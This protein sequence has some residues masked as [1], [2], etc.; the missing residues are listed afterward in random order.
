MKVLIANNAKALTAALAEHDN[1]A[2]VEAEYGDE[3]VEGALATLA[4]HGKYSH[5]P[6]PCIAPMIPFRDHAV[7]GVLRLKGAKGAITEE[8]LEKLK[9]SWSEMVDGA[10][11]FRS[12]VVAGGEFKVCEF[13]IDA[14]GISHVDL[15][16]L[17]GIL[18]LLG[19][20]RD[21]LVDGDGLFWRVAAKVDLRGAHHLESILD[22]IP[23]LP[24]SV[25]EI[26][27]RI[28]SQLHAWWGWNE[29]NRIYPPQD[30]SVADVTVQIWRAC[31]A[32]ERI[33][34]GEPSHLHYGEIWL[35]GQ[36]A[37]NVESFMETMRCGPNGSI[38]V[39]RRS[40]R[41]CGHL[42]L[43]PRGV[44]AQAMA[45]YNLDT[46]AIT[47]SLADPIEGVNCEEIVKDL[48]G[49][50]AGGRDV[51]AGSPRGKVMEIRE[52]RRASAAIAKAIGNHRPR[53]PGGG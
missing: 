53:R 16:T 4:H 9:K 42:Y 17:G 37:L 14:I 21:D 48:W 12:P 24:P 34:E 50:E 46:S 1:T 47:V 35:A 6:A 49:P 43:T 2:T 18:G 40:N 26:A 10:E 20:R 3:V 15:D 25:D 38:V 31:L 22:G 36:E 33:L 44:L 13:P 52:L 8:Q 51:V 23:L 19:R 39:V 11:T 30:G 7:K 32:I 45:F 41:F 29:D 28:R 5:N 27:N